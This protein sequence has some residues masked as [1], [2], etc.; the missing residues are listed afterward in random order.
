MASRTGMGPSCCCGPGA[1]DPGLWF[2]PSMFRDLY[3]WC[4]VHGT[5][6]RR[7][8]CLG[9][10]WSCPGRQGEEAA[11]IYPV[12]TPGSQLFAAIDVCMR[13]SCGRAACPC[14]V[15]Q[16]CAGGEALKGFPAGNWR[17]RDALVMG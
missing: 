7:L 16:R 12:S 1:S 8:R 17:I 3:C 2:Q 6:S 9:C 4:L 15:G 11:K 13:N 10:H 5:E 14:V